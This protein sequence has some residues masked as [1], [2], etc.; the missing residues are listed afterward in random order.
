MDLTN[1]FPSLR[2]LMTPYEFD[3][4]NDDIDSVAWE[5]VCEVSVPNL[6]EEVGQAVLNYLYSSGEQHPDAAAQEPPACFTFRFALLTDK[7]VA[8]DYSPC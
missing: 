3:P 5:E 4:S 1:P 6:A 8:E 2:L 7:Q